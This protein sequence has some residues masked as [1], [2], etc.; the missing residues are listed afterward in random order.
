MVHFHTLCSALE[1]SRPPIERI[2]KP[3]KD[4]RQDAWT[5][6]LG[7]IY[8]QGRKVNNASTAQELR[9]TFEQDAGLVVTCYK[10]GIADF[11]RSSYI[12]DTLSHHEEELLSRIF[13]LDDVDQDGVAYAEIVA[14]FN[15][16]FPFHFAECYDLVIN[17]VRLKDLPEHHQDAIKR[18]MLAWG[19]QQAG[20]PIT[21]QMKVKLSRDRKMTGLPLQ[22][23]QGR[24]RGNANA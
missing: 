19:M 11:Y 14:D 21:K 12:Q 4:W 2:N 18:F 8:K 17:D 16:E 23:E 13:S 24:P 7:A 6:A 15:A 10:R 9:E 1:D 5:E 3:I 22:L 20:Y